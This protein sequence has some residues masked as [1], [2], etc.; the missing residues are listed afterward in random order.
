MRQVKT[1]M[2]LTENEHGDVH[3]MLI[4]LNFLNTE[5]VYVYGRK[6]RL[7]NFY[8]SENSLLFQFAIL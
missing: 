4:V 6:L 1:K 7:L 8:I 3:R 2:S 5:S